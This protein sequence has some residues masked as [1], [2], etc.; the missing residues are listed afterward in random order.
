MVYGEA[1]SAWAHKHAPGFLV[2]QMV[3][4]L[5]AVQ[6]AWFQSLGREGPL[7]KGNTPVFSPGES[8]G[9][10]IPWQ[11]TVPGMAKSRT[12]LND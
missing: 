12:Q 10:R 9:Q 8:H 7:E 1:E 11:A 2:A 5:P 6:E 4:S 3:K